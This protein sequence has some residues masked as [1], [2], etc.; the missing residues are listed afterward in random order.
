MSHRARDT[1]TVPSLYKKRIPQNAAHLLR[2]NLA[3]DGKGRSKEEA[4]KGELW[5][6]A[7]YRFLKEYEF[8]SDFLL[9]FLFWIYI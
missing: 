7:V 2:R 8:I 4:E 1:S 9:V 3:G 5:C 6:E